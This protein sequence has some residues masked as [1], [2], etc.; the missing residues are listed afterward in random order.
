MNGRWVPGP[1]AKLFEKLGDAPLI[2]EDLGAV[3]PEVT[4]LRDKFGFPGIKLLQFAF[5][6]DPQAPTFLPYNY[7]RNSVAFTGTHDNDTTRGWFEKLDEKERRTALDYLGTSVR[8]EIHWDMLRAVWSSVANVA[9]APIQDLLGLGTE[10]RM[11]LPGT[12]QGNWEWR[13]TELP[14]AQVQTRLK[15]LTQIYGRSAR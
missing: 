11:N 10:A 3:T 12:S 2:A 5:G 15:E 7:D 1:G 14:G 4:A 13:L 9:I 8:S 6:T